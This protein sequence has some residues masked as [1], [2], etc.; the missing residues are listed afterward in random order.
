METISALCFVNEPHRGVRG[1]EVIPHGA[2]L[3]P[4]LLGDSCARGAC[5]ACGARG[6]QTVRPMPREKEVVGKTHWF[7]LCKCVIRSLST[8]KW[9]AQGG[10]GWSE[11]EG[12]VLESGV[13]LT[14]QNEVSEWAER[15]V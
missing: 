15:V 11:G 3:H 4:R 8:G 2:M 13:E 5:G 1:S 14:R 12:L 9:V 6:A 10:L 7:M